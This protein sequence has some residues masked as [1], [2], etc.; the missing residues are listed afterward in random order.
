MT[1]IG[2][3]GALGGS[4]ITSGAAIEDP[5]LVSSTQFLELLVAQ[6]ENQNPLEP[7]EGT[8]FVTQLAEFANLEQLTSM[9]AG[10]DAVNAGQAGLLSQQSIQMLGREV[11]FPGNTVALP[12]DDS[13]ELNYQLNG[14]APDLVIEVFDENGLKRGEILRAP[15]DAGLNTFTWDGRVVTP[16]GETT[17]D[18]GSYR[19]TVSA[20][21]GAS[22]IPAQTFGSGR[23]TGIT[24][25]NGFPE[26]MLGDQRIVP[27]DVLKVAS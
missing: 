11:T 27:A 15:R 9:N 3:V 21:D 17:L 14:A 8:Q 26:L 23:V 4:T 1:S 13:V 12:E 18:A 22:S 25:E 24:Y 19:F 10:L 7:L 5:E 20:S 16:D 2:D 6:L